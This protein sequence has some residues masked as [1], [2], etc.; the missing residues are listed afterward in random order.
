VIAQRKLLGI[1]AIADGTTDAKNASVD[2]PLAILFQIPLPPYPSS[3]P[4]SVFK[5][6]K[7]SLSG[8]LSHTVAQCDT[9]GIFFY[10]F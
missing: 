5:F 10:F 4:T 1:G 2:G 8:T 6:I 9:T 3:P 7:L